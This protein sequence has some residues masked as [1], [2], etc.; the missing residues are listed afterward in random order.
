A[1]LALTL[2]SS[3]CATITRGATEEVSFLSTP[4]GATVT[5][6]LGI[7]CETPCT[8]DIKRRD[9]FEATF[10]LNGESKTVFVDTEVAGGGVAGVAGNILLGGLVGATVDVATGAGLNH[11]P[12]PVEV[13]FG[14]EA[15][16]PVQPPPTNSED[17]PA[18]PETVTA[19]VEVFPPVAGSPSLTEGSSYASFTEDQIAAYCAQDWDIRRNAEGRTEYNP[20]TQ[21]SAFN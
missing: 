2:L 10:E 18:S 7:G 9:T 5:T 12:N 3:G 15:F 20:C 21:R 17:A 16:E 13:V 11:V 19:P 4:P 6:S 1:V 14:E 8:M